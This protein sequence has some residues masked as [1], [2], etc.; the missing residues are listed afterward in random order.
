MKTLVLKT[1]AKNLGAGFPGDCNCAA[2]ELIAELLEQCRRRIELAKTA[3]R[4]AR[5]LSAAR[6]VSLFVRLSHKRQC[7]NEYPQTCIQ[8]L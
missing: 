1:D 6:Q 4:D 8:S 5:F 7:V 3:F 2:V